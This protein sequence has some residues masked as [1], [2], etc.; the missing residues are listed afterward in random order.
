MTTENYFSQRPSLLNSKKEKKAVVK[1]KKYA[2]CDD[3][4]CVGDGLVSM[5]S[6]ESYSGVDY[7][8]ACDCSFGDFFHEKY[9]YSRYSD[10]I[11]KGWFQAP[12]QV[13]R[14]KNI[15]I[16]ILENQRAPF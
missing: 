16:V 14:V 13:E 3:G 5:R 4:I 1:P 7:E 6:S 12:W 11:S 9:R 15:R 2:I 8:V 10:Q